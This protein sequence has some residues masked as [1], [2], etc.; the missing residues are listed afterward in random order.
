MRGFVLS[1]INQPLDKFT[2]TP[3]LL[4]GN[5]IKYSHSLTKQ[6]QDDQ[7]FDC[8]AQVQLHLLRMWTLREC[9]FPQHAEYV[10][11]FRTCV[12]KWKVNT[13]NLQM[14]YLVSSRF[15]EGLF[16]DVVRR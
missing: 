5:V 11:E 9:E 7:R 2:T 15:V 1:D 4:E 3:F 10:K 6:V 12:I 16:N 8:R 13:S 14:G